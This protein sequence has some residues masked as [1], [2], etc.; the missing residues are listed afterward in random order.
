LVKRRIFSADALHTQYAFCW[1]VKRWDGD[2]V[3]I[4]KDNQANLAEYLRL[5]FTEP[6][7]DC[8]DWRTAPHAIEGQR[9]L[10]GSRF[11]SLHPPTQYVLNGTGIYLG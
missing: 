9:L 4:A 2:Y 1:S 11:G 8:R 10:G 7:A 3:L 6:P 5:F